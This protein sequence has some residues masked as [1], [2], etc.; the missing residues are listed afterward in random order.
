[1]SHQM[2]KRILIDIF[3]L[4][5]LI[6]PCIRWG[7]NIPYPLAGYLEAAGVWSYAFYFWIVSIVGSILLIK[8]VKNRNQWLFVI[9]IFLVS[10]LVIVIADLI[11]LPSTPK[12]NVGLMVDLSFML[13]F[14]VCFGANLLA[15]I[16]VQLFRK[17]W[18]A[19]SHPA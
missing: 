13:S 15:F 11:E 3:I 14:P 2:S 9:D 17:L 12:Y 4:I 7:I 18:G 6:I 16:I 8:F 19:N 10:L 5:F 1:M